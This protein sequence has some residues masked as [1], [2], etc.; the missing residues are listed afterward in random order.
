ME[1]FLAIVFQLYPGLYLC[2][3]CVCFVFPVDHK[4]SLCCPH[5]GRQPA[6]IFVC[7]KFQ[8]VLSKASGQIIRIK[9]S[10]SDK[11]FPTAGSESPQVWD[12]LLNYDEASSSSIPSHVILEH[13]TF[14]CMHSNLMG[15]GYISETSAADCNTGT[16][17]SRLLRKKVH[18]ILATSGVANQMKILQ[19]AEDTLR[20]KNFHTC[21]DF[22]GGWVKTISTLFD[23]VY[24]RF[25][26]NDFHSYEP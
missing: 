16:W 21:Q 7:S 15:W 19:G 10:T 12:S 17:D 22:T 25:N 3:N 6:Q 11:R 4:N 20:P 2:W 9:L 23:H 26:C 1:Q 13:P 24:L 14:V 8:F 18:L 5:P